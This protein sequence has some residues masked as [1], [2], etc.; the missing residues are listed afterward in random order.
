MPLLRLHSEGLRLRDLEELVVKEL[1]SINE[2]GMPNAGLAD[3]TPEGVGGHIAIRIEVVVLIVVPPLQGHG[4]NVV[5]PD[6]QRFPEGLRILRARA[7][8]SHATDRNGQGAVPEIL[9]PKHALPGPW[10]VLVELVIGIHLCKHLEPLLCPLIQLTD[11]WDEV[12]GVS[13]H[14]LPAAVAR[15]AGHH[16]PGAERIVAARRDV[17]ALEDV[18]SQNHQHVRPSL[19]LHCLRVLVNGLHLEHTISWAHKVDHHELGRQEG[20]HPF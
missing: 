7:V 8:R 18:A 16:D 12:T 2:L 4:A 10:N 6:V 14:G 11:A 5:N 9:G 15:D 1:N 19:D 20:A 3:S 13:A 17:L